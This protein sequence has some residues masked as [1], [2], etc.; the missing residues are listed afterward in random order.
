MYMRPWWGQTEHIEPHM[1]TTDQAEASLFLSLTSSC[2]WTGPAGLCFPSPVTALPFRNCGQFSLDPVFTLQIL[3]RFD[4]S[5]LPRP[6][7]LPLTLFL[8]KTDISTQP[9]LLSHRPLAQ[10]TNSSVLNK[11]LVPDFLSTE[12]LKIRIMW[13]VSLGQNG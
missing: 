3:L 10:W 9:Y 7:D 2:L 4:A 11:P 13:M 5:G 6:T 1:W 12:G 8:H